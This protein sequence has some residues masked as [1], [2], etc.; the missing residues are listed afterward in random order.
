MTRKLMLPLLVAGATLAVSPA[1]N[2]ASL[3]SKVGQLS[4]KVAGLT[5]AVSGL[6]DTDKG[7][8]AAIDRVNNRVDTVVKNLAPVLSALPDVAKALTALADP[9]TGLAA[10]NLARPQIVNFTVEDPVNR[11]NHTGININGASPGFVKAQRVSTD[12]YALQFGSD[13]SKRIASLQLM[14]RGFEGLIAP[15]GST[16]VMNCGAG[17]ATSNAC[18]PLLAGTGIP[19]NGNTAIVTI[20]G[21]E[22]TYGSGAQGATFGLA[23][24]SG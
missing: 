10:L 24:I 15:A 18:Q 12:T 22:N 8:N 4:G 23:E 9:T 20:P 14:F 19:N 3:G 11:P 13:V 5:K 6:E 7:Q 2:A 21:A 17:S 16:S 1:A